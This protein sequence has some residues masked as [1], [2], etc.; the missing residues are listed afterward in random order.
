M[1]QTERMN[2]DRELL[3]PI[4]AAIR[5]RPSAR[6]SVTGLHS[7]SPHPD[8]TREVL[9]AQTLT[10]TRQRQEQLPHWQLCREVERLCFSASLHHAHLGLPLLAHAQAMGAPSGMMSSVLQHA[11]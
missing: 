9:T 5:R 4:P 2:S 8:I 7:L 10:E 3:H 1:R 6:L 11:V